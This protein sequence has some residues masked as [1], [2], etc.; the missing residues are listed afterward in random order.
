MEADFLAELSATQQR[1]HVSYSFKK[2]NN[3]SIHRL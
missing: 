2:S 3:Y 1:F